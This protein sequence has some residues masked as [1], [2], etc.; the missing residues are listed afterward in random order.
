M[1]F[2]HPLLRPFAPAVLRDFS[3]IHVWHYREVVFASGLPEGVEAPASYD[4]GG[5][6]L[7]AGRVGKGRIFVLPGGWLPR[8]SQLA[9]SSKF[10]PLLYA[11]LSKAGFASD[12]RRQFFVGDKLPDGAVAVKPGVVS[13]TGPGGPAT[14]AVNLPVVESDLELLDAGALTRLGVTVAQEPPRDA[15]PGPNAEA[16][17]QRERERLH[18]AELEQQQRLWRWLLVGAVLCLLGETWLSGRK[19]DAARGDSSQKS[20]KD[21]K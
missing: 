15:Q 16:Q 20:A 17:R 4:K 19:W 11:M 14:M 1:D 6:A 18:L 5:P 12:A 2:Q 9:L 21:A 13:Q 3:K 7:L 8:D 10:V